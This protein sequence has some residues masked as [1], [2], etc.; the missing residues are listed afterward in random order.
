MTDIGGLSSSASGENNLDIDTQEKAMWRQKSEGRD[1]CDA[2]TSQ[3]E[4]G[5]A[6]DL[7][8]PA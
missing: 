1:W 2:A 3:T 4:T 5:E 8:Q 6:G 7:A